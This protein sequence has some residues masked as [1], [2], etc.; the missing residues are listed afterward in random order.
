MDTYRSDDEITLKLLTAAAP[1]EV[2]VAEANL[3]DRPASE[4][5]WERHSGST[6]RLAYRIT[7][8][9]DNAKDVVQLPT[10]YRG[11]TQAPTV[12]PL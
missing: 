2:L 8:N 10:H 4:E 11:D 12:G 6:F 7:R 5:L 3:G 9:R 1:D